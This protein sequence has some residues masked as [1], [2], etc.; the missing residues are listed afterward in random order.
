MRPSA[1]LVL[2]SAL[3][4]AASG[5]DGFEPR[6]SVATIRAALEA[7]AP[8]ALSLKAL[9]EVRSS[10]KTVLLSL[11]LAEDGS[12][13][14][15]AWRVRPIPFRLPPEAK[16]QA[17]PADGAPFWLEAKG[18]GAAVLLPIVLDPPHAPSGDVLSHWDSG[19]SILRAPFFPPSTR[20]RLLTPNGKAIATIE[21]DDR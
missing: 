14:V 1:S 15:S 2:V 7:Q 20:Y 21:A 9:P 3:G 4:L 5:C 8:P 6:S 13:S 10:P 17:A 11:L 18:V 19:A 16:P 12:A